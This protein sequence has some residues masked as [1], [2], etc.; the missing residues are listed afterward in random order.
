MFCAMPLICEVG[1]EHPTLSVLNRYQRSTARCREYTKRP[2]C[3]V[4]TFR[5]W[6]SPSMSDHVVPL[7]IYS[8]SPSVESDLQF[9]VEL[10]T[11]KLV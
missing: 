10:V 11:N 2:T 6:V 1:T 9:D 4:G 5:G 7:V 8:D 3:E